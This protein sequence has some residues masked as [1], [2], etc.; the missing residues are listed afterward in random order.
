MKYFL[1]SGGCGDVVYSLP[2]IDALGGGILYLKRYNQYNKICDQYAMLKRLLELQDCIEEV[3]EYPSTD[4][5][6]YDDKI[7]IDHDLDKFRINT[8]LAKRPLIQV[9]LQ[10][11]GF[12]PDCYSIPFLKVDKPQIPEN[13]S[14]EKPF[15]LINRTKRYQDPDF[16]WRKLLEKV[17]ENYGINVFFIGLKDEYL[18]FVNTVGY[19]QL[20]ITNDFLDAAR[21][22][23]ASDAL[24]CNQSCCLTIAQA[25]GKKYYLEVAPN[26]TNCILNLSNETLLNHGKSHS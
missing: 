3:R 5:F 8:D 11:F 17:V 21:Y 24:Y 13:I 26:H 19:V 14:G 9:C 22:I 16:D 6:Q 2:T 23:A 12:I 20:L 18:H 10:K 25:L 4:F 7:L 15:A 1:S